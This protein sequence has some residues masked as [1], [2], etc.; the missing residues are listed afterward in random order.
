MASS[1]EIQVEQRRQYIR[2]VRMEAG[3]TTL[4]EALDEMEAE[5]DQEDVAWIRQKILKEGVEVK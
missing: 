5:M 2:L 4:K 1:K 3:K